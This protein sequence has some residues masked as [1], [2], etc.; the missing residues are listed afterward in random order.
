MS[1]TKQQLTTE[2]AANF[3]YRRLL[4]YESALTDN[5]VSQGISALLNGQ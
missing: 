2:V 1:K 5:Q 3:D 4:I